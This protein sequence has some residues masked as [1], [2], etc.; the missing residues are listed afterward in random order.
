METCKTIVL[1]QPEAGAS[2]NYEIPTNETAQLSF[3]PDQISGI[4]LNDFGGLEI[5]FLDGSTATLTNFQELVDTGNLL[6]LNDGTLIDPAVLTGALGNAADPTEN[7]DILTIV[8]PADNVTREINLEPGQKYVLDFDFAQPKAA[9]VQDGKLVISFANDGIL[10]LNN[11]ED[12]MNGDLPAE[13]SLASSDTIISGEELLTSLTLAEAAPSESVLVFEEEET[14]D[15]RK[16]EI[17]QADLEGEDA[18]GAGNESDLAYQVSQVEPASGTDEDLDSIAEALQD[19]EPAAG[20]TGGASGRGGYGFNSNPNT[21][22]LGSIDDVGPINP[23]AL[24][25]Q[26]PQFSPE[27][28]DLEEQGPLSPPDS[29]PIASGPFTNR[30][31]ETNLAGGNL[32]DNGQVLV[33]FGTDGPGTILPNGS[34]EVECSVLNND[35]SSGGVDVVISEI[36]PGYFGGVTGQGYVGTAGGEVVFT[37][38]IDPDTGEYTYTQFKPFDHADPNDANDEICLTFGIVAEDKDGDTTTTEIKVIVADDA[39]L[40]LDQTP[41][42]HDESD[43]NGNP[44]QLMGNFAVNFGQD[45]DGTITPEGTFAPGGSL[46]GGTLSSG[47]DPITVTPTANGYEGKLADNTVIFTLEIDPATGDYTFTQY[48]PLD[49]ADGSNPDDVITLDFDVT[50]TDFDGD[51]A[52]GTIRINVVDDAPVIAGPATETIDESDLG[53]IV[54]T[55][56]ISVDFGEDGAGDIAPNGDFTPGGSLDNGALTSGGEPIAVTQTADGYVGKLPDD[57]VAFTLE[58]DPLTGDYEF[59]LLKPLD[60]ADDSNPNDIITLQFGVTATDFDGDTANTTITIK[61]KDDAPEFQPNGPKPDSGL[62]TVDETNLEGGNIV[63]TGSL[64]ADFGEDAPGSYAFTTD[65]AS[66]GSKLG[67]VLS[68]NGVPV[69][70]SV[71]GTTYSGV[72]NGVTIFTL[73]LDPESGDYT[74]TQFQELD[75]ADANNDNDVITLSFGVAASDS[76]G[77]SVFGEIVIN[78]RDDAAVANDDFNMYDVT[79]GGTNGNVITGLN[80][81]PGAADNL[82]EDIPNTVTKISFGGNTVDVPQDGTDATIE[83]DFGI[84]HI[85]KDGVYTYEIKPGVTVSGTNGSSTLDPNSGDVAGI[86]NS[87]TKNGITVTSANGADLT[88]VTQDGSGI[89]IAGGGSDKVWP[90][91]E[92]LELTFDQNIKMA[93]LTIAD[94]GANNL[95]DGIDFAVYLASDPTTP[96]IGEVGIENLTVVDGRVVFTINADT[97]GSGAEIVQIDVFSTNAGQYGASSFLLH[98]VTVTYG[99]LDCIQDQFVYTLRDGDGD[100]DTAILDLKGKD[101]TDNTPVI[102]EPIVEYVDETFLGPIVETGTVQADFFGEGPGTIAGNDDFTFSGSA[103]NGTLSSGGVSVVVDQV[104]DKYVG[105]AGAVTVFELM[106][107]ADG[108]YTFKLYEPLDHADGNDDNDVISLNFGVIATDADGDTDTATITVNVKD[109][110]PVANDDTVGATEGGSVTGNVTNNDDGGEDTP[111]TV[112][113]VTFNGTDYPVPAAGTTD[114]PGQYGTLTIAASGAFTYTVTDPN[115]PDGTDTFTYTLEDFDGDQDTAKLKVK[116]SPKDDVP[117]VVDP[118]EKT[119][120]ETALDGGPVMVSGKVDANYFT[121]TPGAITPNGDFEAQADLLNGNLTHNGVDIDV[122]VEGNSYVG[123]AG[124]QTIFTLEVQPN[125]DFKFTLFENLDHDDPTRDNEVIELNFG[126]TATDSDGDTDTAEISIRVKDDVP[127]ISEKFITIDESDLDTGPLVVTNTVS[128]DYGEDGPGEIRPTGYFEVKIDDSGTTQPL[129]KGG[130]LVT[131]TQDGN[132]Y[133]GKLADGTVVLTLEIDSQTGEYTYKQFTSVDHPDTTD[134]DDVMW[135]KFQVE[136]VDYDGDTDTTFIGIDLKDDGPKINST[137]RPVYEEDLRDGGMIDVVRDVS[138]FDFGED[139]AGEIQ[140]DGRFELLLKDGGTPQ[141]LQSNGKD[142]TVTK[143]GNGYVGKLADGTVIFTMQIHP[144]NGTYHY[145]QFEALDHFE[146]HDPADDVF[147]LKFGVE[148]VDAD[149]DTDTAWINVDVNDDN[150][151]AVDDKITVNESTGSG[152][153]DVILND[154]VGADEP[155]SVTMIKFGSQMKTIADGGSATISGTYGDLTIN[156]DGTYTYVITATSVPDTAF[157]TFTYKL[158]DFDGDTDTAELKL[159]LI[160]DDDVPVLVQPAMEIVDETFL[161]PITKTGQ[162]QADFFG[163]GPGTFMATGSF[164]SSGSKLGGDLT[165]NGVDVIVTENGGTYTGKAGTETIFTLKVNANGSYEFKLFG[166]LDHADGNDDNDIIKLDFGVKAVDK[167]GDID[168]GVIQVKVKDDVPTIQDKFGAVDET[169]LVNG[170]IVS[171]RPITFDYGEDGPGVIK[172][173]GTFM[174]VSA[175]NG[176]A[177]PLTYCG[178]AVNVTQTANGYKGMVGSLLIFTLT[179]DPANGTHTYTQYE[180]MDHKEGHNPGD[181][182]FW[183]KFGVD[184]MDYDGDSDSAFIIVDVHDDEPVANTDVNVF[185]GNSTDGNV[186]TGENGG[187]HAADK[188]SQDDPTLVNKIS[189]GSVEKA[190]TT[191]GDTVI[192]GQY[193][194]L[195]IGADGDYVYVLNDQPPAPKEDYNIYTYE[196]TYPGGNHD[197]G[198]IKYLKAVYNEKTDD[199]SFEMVICDPS[200]HVK[201]DGFTLVLS[202]GPN[203]KGIGGELGIFYFDASDENNPVVSVYGYNGTNTNTSWKDGSPAGGTQA[204]DKIA[205]SLNG[206]SPFDSV[207]VGVNDKGYHVYKFTLDATVI[208]QHDPLYGDGSDWDGVAFAEKMGI[209][210]HPVAN[211]NTDYDSN[212]YLTQWNPGKTGWYDDNYLNTDVDTVCDVCN[213]D[214]DPVKSDIGYNQRS[215]TLDGI[216]V[217]VGDPIYNSL[218][219]GYLSWVDVGDGAGIGINGNGSSKVWSP[220]E[221]LQI[222]F[223]TGVSKVTLDI[224][225]IGSNNIDDG[226]D[227]KIYLEG[228]SQP[229]EWEFDINSANPQDGVLMNIMINAEDFGDALIE[230]IDVFTIKNSDLDPASFLL[231]SVHAECPEEVVAG[232]DIFEYQI[233]DKDGDTSTAYLVFNG[234]DGE[235][236]NGTKFAE[237][238]NGTDFDDVVYGAGGNDVLFGHGGNDVF[239]FLSTDDGHDTIKDFTLGEDSIDLSQLLENFDDVNDAIGDFV[240]LSTSNGDTTISV[241]TNGSGNAAAAVDIVTLD[242]TVI[243]LNDLLGQN[244]LVS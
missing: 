146:G 161:G 224:A 211:L 72:A 229:I 208:Q 235:A 172:G 237:V 134:P 137:S 18:I 68:S 192:D 104:G 16:T 171:T 52:T 176:P 37:L 84:L 162:L 47:G 203:P 40:V 129:T 88:W 136:I 121:D 117:V 221:V 120:D 188:L 150:P 210:L 20:E 9:E 236:I 239:V 3:G 39:P 173:N 49:H 152:S 94:I 65:N 64:D 242:N 130:E 43:F 207:E 128:H 78:V 44:A 79:N 196:T 170:P 19:V 7:S 93:E 53:P 199:F 95:D 74:Y 107:E 32:V 45:V 51:S 204:P 186:L 12:V 147:W 69:V 71:A 145:K 220:G 75:H 8:G 97:Y 31:D 21:E 153:G 24:N 178:Q 213:K 243:D 85:N 177:E 191:S 190:V 138:F 50:V 26:A 57:S 109:D 149:G 114:V 1:A 82:S 38:V 215:L 33:D 34:V 112:V 108:D 157:E 181:D 206:N 35:L 76:E 132:G 61:V 143:D 238:L 139:G 140:A 233:V 101:L 5:S 122:T 193:G 87:I 194:K 240:F 141:Q 4:K 103:K 195:T 80:G 111:A 70:V 205:S 164:D 28:L 13:L 6:Y 23:T 125:G 131:V 2:V 217:S 163:D 133:I 56:S 225:D 36:I 231:H 151:D 148:I 165:S 189:F 155:G 41:K 228:Q 42:T 113:K 182:V 160:G 218:D 17:A 197:A 126:V 96:I 73:T 10:I 200:S 67:G 66:T 174:K 198:Y 232:T 216:T 201:T 184:I 55:G 54:E 123:K 25:Y 63:E 166:N 30:L 175:T 168:V 98:D 234:G 89:G 167:D 230:R 77:E 118:A 212:G 11:Y 100:T 144:T 223:D 15:V 127:H 241:D 124:G 110:A 116:V 90:A 62:E 227:F 92:T 185:T 156:S 60:H 180:A 91:G 46:A 135:L 169:D 214:F 159:C 154:T 58:I 209:W 22:P 183:L 48:G 187:A 14:E 142:V 179:I 226:I 99:G 219:K 29:N 59:T 105:K 119:V 115:N 86:Q 27:R 81:G 202:D 102:V 158:S 244:A 106:I 83:G 222:D